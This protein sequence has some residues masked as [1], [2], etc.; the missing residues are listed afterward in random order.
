MA[1]EPKSFWR[2]CRRVFRWCRI[3]VLLFVLAGAAFLL[4]LNQVGLPAFVQERI[5]TE[6]RTRA[7]DV[8]LGRVR[9]RGFHELSARNI[10]IGQT[11]QTNGPRLLL[12]DAELR[13]DFRALKRF[14]LK[15]ESVALRKAQLLWAIATTNGPAESLSINDISTEVHFTD[16]DQW[17]LQHFDGYFLGTHLHLLASITNGSAMARWFSASKPTN[18]SAW[19]EQFDRWAARLKQV[20][21]PPTSVLSLKVIGDGRDPAG[22][23]ADFNLQAP[24]AETPWGYLK[25]LSLTAG[26]APLSRERGEVEARIDLLVSELETNDRQW[27]IGSNTLAG[28]VQLSLTNHALLSARFDWNLETAATRWVQATNIHLLTATLPTTN[29]IDGPLKTTLMLEAGEIA[30]RLVQTRTN[31]LTAEL[32]HSLTNFTSID[33][34]WQLRIE[35]LATQWGQAETVHLTGRVVSPNLAA[36]GPADGTWGPWSLIDTLQLDWE[37]QLGPVRS[38][39][40]RLESLYCTG[41]WRAPQVRVQRFHSAL[42]GGQFEASANLNV[43]T[44]EVGS[45]LKFDFDLH[46][47]KPLL[48]P[49]AR[50]WLEQFTWTTPPHVTAEARLILPVWTNTQPAW[51]AKVLPTV[52]LA[53]AFEGTSGAFRGIPVSAAQSHFSLTNSIWHLPDLSVNRPE[54]S[55]RLDY[56]GDMR[57]QDF[58]WDIESHIDVKALE[59]V[60]DEPEMRALEMFQFNGA[61]DIRGE[62]WGRWRERESVGFRGRVLATNFTFRGERWERFNTDVSYTNLVLNFTDA[63]ILR[64]G[65]YVKAPGGAYDFREHVI[66]L[67]NAVST[68][69]PGLATKVMGPKIQEIMRPYHFSEPPTVRVNGRVPTTDVDKADLHFEV[70]GSGFDYWRFH[71]PHVSGDVFWRG[72]FLSVTNVQASFYKGQLTWAGEFD[73]GAPARTDFRF[74]GHAEDVDLRMLMRDLSPATNHLEGILSANLVITA[75]NSEDWKSWQGFG[76]A[77]LRDGFL[78]NIPIFGFLSP[79]LNKVVPG[80]GQSRASA[81]AATFLIDKSVIRTSDLEVRSAALRLQYEGSAD[82]KGAVD[83]KMQAEILRDAW[84]VGR[85]VS[86]A[87]WPLAKVFEYKISGTLADPKSEPLYIP[88]FLFFP[89]HPIKTLR[90]IFTEMEAAT[91]SKESPRN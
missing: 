18:A 39:D 54:G 64:D 49:A 35:Q 27:R 9:L 56:T 47:I 50:R 25:H 88:R 61:P 7:V 74:R 41:G 5:E 51:R 29:A 32:F 72:D 69:D 80:L 89:F 59:P 63:R 33:G 68:L 84:A 28:A 34:H 23:R 30:S 58:H 24:S 37:C 22:F 16:G 1:S 77:N 43:A 87:L 10:Q 46:Q 52:E 81:A 36:P 70:A 26:L 17:E 91:P 14:Q 62:I 67:T 4:Y 73:F 83:A 21:L 38:P 90:D 11:G 82:F 44:R 31:H 15:I 12:P 42:Y 19:Q 76:D 3:S 86:L 60:L 66:F 40:L 8:Q 2:G 57:T 85:V 45:Q 20:Q 48:T 53:G 75:A 79:I 65:R 13:L 78:W 6:L 55:A 71:L